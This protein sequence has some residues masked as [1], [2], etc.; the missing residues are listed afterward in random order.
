MKSIITLTL[1][2]FAFSVI[3]QNSDEFKVPMLGDMAP[4]FKATTTNGDL[5]FPDDYFGKWKVLFSHPADFTPVCSSEILELAY[6]QDEYKKINTA[7]AVISTDGL[8]SHLQWKQSLE[9]MKYKDREPVTID[10]AIISDVGLDI[11]KQYGMIHPKSS[12]TKDVRGVFII[13]DNNKIRAIFYYPMTI[14]RNM[15]EILRSVKALQ[16]HEKS[17]KLVPANWE[18]GDDLLL[19]SPAT[20]EEAKKLAEK[21]NSKQ[22]SY[23][24]FMWFEK[25]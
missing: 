6:L 21:A 14:G 1:A 17:Q 12:S 23:S 20:A 15:D 9:E 8:N 5:T 10:F 3:A 16:T 22:Y 4:K 2:I 19:Q 11:S 13:D 24:W 25:Q 7:I 18:P